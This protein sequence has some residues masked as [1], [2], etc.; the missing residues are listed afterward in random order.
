MTKL[1]RVFPM[2]VVPILSHSNFRQNDN[3][4]NVPTLVSR[5]LP[6]KIL[7]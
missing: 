3:R 2:V 7:W 4:K 5:L 6:V 1:G